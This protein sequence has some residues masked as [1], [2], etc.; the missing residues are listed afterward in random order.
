VTERTDVDRPTHPTGFWF[1]FFG[2]LAERCS[3]YGVR[4][5]LVM[6]LVTVFHYPKPDASLVMHLYMAGCYFAPLIG[7]FVADRYLGKYWTIVAFSVPYVLGQFLV[8]LS[9]QTLMYGALVLLALGSGVIKPNISSLMGM[10]YDQKRPGEDRLRSQAFSWFYVAINL[11]SFFSYNVCPWVRDT[12]GRADEK[13]I[14][15]DPQAGYMAGFMVPAVLMAVALFIFTVGK[16]FYAVESLPANSTDATPPT[17]RWAVVGRV[18]GLFFLVMFFWAIFDQKT[19]TWLYFANDYLDLNVGGT[20]IAPE[21]MQSLNPFFII[22]LTPV[23][24]WIY[25]LLEN[26]G[27]DVRP[28]NKMTAGFLLTA[29]CMGI[30][31]IAAAVATNDDGSITRI[32]VLW[33]AGAFLALTVA[34]LLISVTGLELAYTAAPKSLK[35]FVTALWLMTVGLANLF[36]NTPVSQLYPNDTPAVFS[37]F[38]QTLFSLPKF[39]SATGY[40]SFLTGTML[41]VTVAFVFVARRFNRATPAS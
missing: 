21:R 22:V 23:L 34:E 30:H 33:Q 15:A 31:A 6:Y 36:I 4:I 41:L 2:E 29:A 40:F 19:T 12:V 7:G 1:I 35:S 16:R 24:S 14:L 27:W 8:G 38:G 28:T 25:R 18:G 9:N 37:V 17:G 10:T 11:G 32:S 5:L 26:R 3:F 13:G 39:S 20:R